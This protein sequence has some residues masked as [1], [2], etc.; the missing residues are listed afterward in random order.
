MPVAVSITGVPVI[1]ISGVIELQLSTSETVAGRSP[2]AALARLTCQRGDAFTSGAGIGVESVDGVMRGGD[3]D[4]IVDALA[5]D[6]D[7]REVE[8]LRVDL[9]VH[10]MGEELAELD[11][12]DIRRRQDGFLKILSGSCEIVAIR[13]HADLGVCF[14]SQENNKS[15]QP[16]HDPP[17]LSQASRMRW[18]GFSAKIF[19]TTS[20]FAAGGLSR[21]EDQAQAEL[22]IARFAEAQAGRR[23]SV[24]GRRD[25]AEAAR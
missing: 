19:R 16:H 5:R 18:R 13:G 24:A 6:C 3:E 1:P 4:Y 9:P 23:P 25:L 8:R 22:G 14:Y 17:G 12:R 11:R 10:R 2:A 20:R 7:R 15:N 21:L